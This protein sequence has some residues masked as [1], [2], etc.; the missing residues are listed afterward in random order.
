MAEI[1]TSK[2][3]GRIAP[4]PTGYLHLGHARTFWTAM[5][6]AKAA[7]GTLIYRNEDI[8][9]QRCKAEYAQ[10]ALTDLRWFGLDWSEGPDL[11]GPCAPY[12]QSE[13]THH[14]LKAWERLK[15]RG[16][17]YPCDRS[18]KDVAQASQAPHADDEA[19]EPLY[20]I[21]WRPAPEA[22]QSALTPDGVN[23]RFRVPEGKIIRFTDLRLGECSF[24]GQRDFGDFVIWRRDN[25]PAYELAVVV[26][27]DAMGITEVVRGEDLLRSTARQLLI[28]DALGLSAPD[29][30]HTPL[31]CDANGQRL[32][33]R[34]QALSL[35][36]MRA[37]GK[38]PSELRQSAEWMA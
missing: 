9:P 11:G 34:T 29:F 37:A 10:T 20:P 25:V 38:T 23:W 1:V 17:I 5:E 35:G 6:R 26:D 13:R 7:G 16:V 36:E 2:Y 12:S 32:A 24:E 3:R 28:Y 4:T 30:F 22:G 21:D 31:L 8:D 18:R 15:E 14:F 27:D 33:K 19:A